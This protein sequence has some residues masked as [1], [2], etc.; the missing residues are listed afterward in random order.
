MKKLGNISE[1][2]AFVQA[3]S[4]V[5]ASNRIVAA[6]HLLEIFP[7]AHLSLL[8][9][10]MQRHPALTVLFLFPAAERESS[11]ERCS[12]TRSGASTRS[13]LCTWRDC[14]DEAMALI[15]LLLLQE[16]ATEP[17]VAETQV[18]AVGCS[19]RRAQ[20]RRMICLFVSAVVFSLSLMFS[21]CRPQP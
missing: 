12:P 18:A 15:N 17:Q 5:L 16:N 13:S 4:E 1:F 3:F 19:S 7:A 8:A 10:G 14:S 2:A 21:G 20:L 11:D 9:N 6:L